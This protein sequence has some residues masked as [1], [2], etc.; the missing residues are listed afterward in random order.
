MNGPAEKIYYIL[1]MTSVEDGHP[2]VPLLA[3]LII[4]FR[5]ISCMEQVLSRFNGLI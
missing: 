1:A 5:I 3:L 4:V 2:F